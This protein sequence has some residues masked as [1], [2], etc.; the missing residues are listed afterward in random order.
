[1]R[2]AVFGVKAVLRAVECII[3]R[4]LLKPALAVFLYEILGFDLLKIDK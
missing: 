4:T 1:M 2:G 3:D